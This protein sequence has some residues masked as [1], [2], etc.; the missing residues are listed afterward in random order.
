MSSAEEKPFKLTF[1][2]FV[3]HVVSLKVNYEL[4]DT[5]KILYF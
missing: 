2:C 5:K 3:F 4:K 1:A